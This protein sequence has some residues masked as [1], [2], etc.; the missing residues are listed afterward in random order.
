M[1]V[2][3]FSSNG[4]GRKDNV[5]TEY[6]IEELSFKEHSA[7]IV[8]PNIRN[9]K[10]HWIWRARFW[11]H[12]PQVDKALLERGFHLVYVDVADLFGNQEAVELW[13][14]YYDFLISKYSLNPKVVLEGLSRGGLILYNWASQNTD[15]VACIYADAPSVTSK[16]GRGDCLMAWAAKKI[17]KLV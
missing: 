10:G 12:E 16:V 9:E 1:L 4:Q 2:I 8:F 3:G 13:N 11:G 14:D 15:K 5:F 17:G 6:R 7:K